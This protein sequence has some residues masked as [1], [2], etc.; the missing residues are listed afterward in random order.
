VPNADCQE[1]GEY[2]GTVKWYS[3]EALRQLAGYADILPP[4]EN[5]NPLIQIFRLNFPEIKDPANRRSKSFPLALEVLFPVIFPRRSL[6]GLNHQAL[7]DSQQTKLVL[8]AAIELPKPV[9]ERGK[10]WNPERITRNSQTSIRNWLTDIQVG[11]S[12]S[13]FSSEYC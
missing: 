12:A 13:R 9:K 7:V 8:Q 11:T 10:G 1:L 6:I 3:P 5:C 4:D 2:H